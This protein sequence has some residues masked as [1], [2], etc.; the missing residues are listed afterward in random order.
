[1]AEIDIPNWLNNSFFET[2]LR[3][4]GYGQNVMVTSSEIE[5]ATGAGDNYACDIWRAK[6]QVTLN[7]RR[8]TLTLIVKAQPTKEELAKV[9]ILFCLTLHISYIRSTFNRNTLYVLLLHTY[10]L[11]IHIYVLKMHR[12]L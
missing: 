6:L 4:G 3:S 7:G 5:R 1:M 9:N 11:H 10:N 2:A 8:S 12:S